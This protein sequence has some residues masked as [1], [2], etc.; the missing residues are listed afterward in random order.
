MYLSITWSSPL[1]KWIGFSMTFHVALDPSRCPTCELRSGSAA[2]GPWSNPH[3]P[4]MFFWPTHPSRYPVWTAMDSFKSAD[5]WDSVIIHIHSY[6][7][8]GISQTTW[9]CPIL[10]RSFSS[11]SCCLAVA[12]IGGSVQSCGSETLWCCFW[13]QI[14][15]DVFF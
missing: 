2:V 10:S 14:S 5:L 7:Y 1:P 4:W 6:W 15:F 3:G 12:K 8:H 9:F 13:R 11:K